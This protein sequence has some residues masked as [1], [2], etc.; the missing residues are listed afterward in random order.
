VAQSGAT[1]ERA[2]STDKAFEG[3]DSQADLESSVAFDRSGRRLVLQRR[4]L[5]FAYRRS[6]LGDLIVTEATFALKPLT[7]AEAA[8]HAEAVKELLR[9]RRDSQP[10]SAASAG[11][12]WKN[13]RVKAAQEPVSSSNNWG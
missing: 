4:D 5:E 13:P 12:A 1:P 10:V 7:E 2:A 8:K 11:C 9:L 3:R 6:S